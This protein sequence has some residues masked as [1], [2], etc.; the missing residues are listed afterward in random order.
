M[1]TSILNTGLLGGILV[2][3]ILIL[4]QIQRPISVDQPVAV[5]GWSTVGGGPRA[6]WQGPEPI[7]VTIVSQ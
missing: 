4:L 6:A 7:P 5:E 1:K 2:V 3:L